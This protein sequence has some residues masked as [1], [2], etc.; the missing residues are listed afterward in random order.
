MESLYGYKEKD[1]LLLAQFIKD[2]K[3]SLTEQFN[4]FSLATGKAKGTVRNLYYALAKK[5]NEDQEFCNKYLNGKAI[6]VNTSKGFS[7]EEERALVKQIIILKNNGKSVRSAIS[8]LANGDIKL[9]LRY[10][11]KYRNFVKNNP[12]E[13][14]QILLEIKKEIGVEV[15][16]RKEDRQVTFNDIQFRRLKSEIDLLVKRISK[17]IR[18]ENETLKSKIEFLE[19]ENLKLSRL[20]YGVVETNSTRCFLNHNQT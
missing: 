2:R 6:K 8:K 11:N 10:Q 18:D 14:E 5:S 12:A 9:A 17:D 20:L 15:K 7:S 4:E 3:D 1:V 13:L 19:N 16:M